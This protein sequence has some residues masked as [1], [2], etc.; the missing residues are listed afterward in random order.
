MDSTSP[1]WTHRLLQRLLIAIPIVIVVLLCLPFIRWIV[2]AIQCG[3]APIETSNFAA[4]YSYTLPNDG[5]YTH[6][7]LF[8]NFACTMSEVD[9]RHHNTLPSPD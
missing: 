3:H 4:A 2:A 7:P 9:G 1:T 6:Y 5:T 8:D